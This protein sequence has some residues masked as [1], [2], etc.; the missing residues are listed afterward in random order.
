MSNKYDDF[1][2]MLLSISML[3]QDLYFNR[4]Y[5]MIFIW[6]YYKISTK[7]VK[8]LVPLLKQYLQCYNMEKR[9]FK[10][11]KFE[12]RVTT[13]NFVEKHC[14]ENPRIEFKFFMF[15]N[16]PVNLCSSNLFWRLLEIQKSEKLWLKKI[17]FCVWV[18]YCFFVFF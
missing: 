17:F 14:I 1:N 10:C 13:F 11:P 9:F 6:C 4:Y 5:S 7:S 16:F 8:N 3:L 15:D 12:S 2:S 18:L